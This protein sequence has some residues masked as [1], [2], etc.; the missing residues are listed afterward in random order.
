[1]FSMVAT[2]FDAMAPPTTTPMRLSK[3]TTAPAMVRP[4][5]MRV[6]HVLGS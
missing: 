5:F 2:E 4:L 6:L 3:R 1:M